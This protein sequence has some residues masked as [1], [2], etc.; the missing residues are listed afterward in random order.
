MDYHGN[1]PLLALAFYDGKANSEIKL[2]AQFAAGVATQVTDDLIVEFG[3]R[4]EDWDST[5]ENILELQYPFLNE[6]SLTVPRDWHSTWAYN[7]GGQYRFSETVAI[8][9]GYL[10]GE[11]AVPDSSFEPIIPDTDAHLL[12][13]GADLDLGQW[14]LSGA[15]G[16]E[17]HEKR[18]KQNSLG[19][20]LGSLLAGQ[21]V[22]TANG[23]Y[24]TDIYLFGL[25]VGYR[26]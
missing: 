2:P 14:T 9:L 11:D 5:D 10:Y 12:T 16:Y 4:W 20:P 3:V 18:N 24:V 1:E 19:D 26:F 7:I 13:V 21:S 15:F 8:N 17:Y 25:S 23:D 6:S 22:G